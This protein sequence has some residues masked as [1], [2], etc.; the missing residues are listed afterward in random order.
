[1]T[2]VF[3]P[4]VQP[5]DKTKRRI[6]LRRA[7]SPIA[8]PVAIDWLKPFTGTWG[9]LGNDNVGDCTAAGAIH[10]TQTI[11]HA[12]LNVDLIFADSDAMTMY[13]AISGYVPGNE[14]TDVGAT[15]Q[16]AL[17]Y[18]RNV[19]LR[20][21]KIA[22]FAQIDITDLS[23]VRNCIALFGSVY[24]GLTIVQSAMDQVNAGKPWTLTGKSSKTLGGHCVPV[25]AYNSTTMKCVTWGQVQAMD[26][27]FFQRYFDEAWVPIS[28]D[29]ITSGSKSPAGI[30]VAML[31]AD[32][33]ALT[34][35]PGPFITK[36]VVPPPVTKDATALLTSIRDQISGFLGK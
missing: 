6:V 26:L 11:A 24:C 2:I 9:M 25:S 23:L 21:H 10:A 12:G 13:Q 28:E 18:W 19:G 22:A 29:W 30:D 7:P 1:M 20:G 14:A 27:T 5:N 16:D 33:M 17:G 31:N 3:T 35:Q 8:P 34:G 32:Y 36:S 15:L 4:G